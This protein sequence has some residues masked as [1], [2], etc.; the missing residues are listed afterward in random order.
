MQGLDP[1][2]R[3]PRAALERDLAVASDPL[4]DRVG[5][6]RRAL[7]G[8]G[9][10]IM[11]LRGPRC[12]RPLSIP[13]RRR[14][15]S[16]LG[17]ARRPGPV[18]TH[19]LVAGQLAS[20][21]PKNSAALIARA[22]PPHRGGVAGGPTPT[23]TRRPGRR[24]AASLDGWPS[25]RCT[26]FIRAG[27]NVGHPPTTALPARLRVFSS[28]TVEPVWVRRCLAFG[29]PCTTVESPFPPSVIRR[30]SALCP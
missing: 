24:D 28:V 1:A 14:G 21:A 4:E 22:G 11:V 27:A 30:A 19:L 5:F 23:P 15:C 17:G 2:G 29:P 20:L 7:D 25:H 12:C 8:P 26:E 9:Q 18:L 10:Q 13:C 6:R 16:P 3:V